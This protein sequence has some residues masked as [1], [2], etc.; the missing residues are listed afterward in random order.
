MIRWRAAKA[1]NGCRLATARSLAGLYPLTGRNAIGRQSFDSWRRGGHVYQCPVREVAGGNDPALRIFIYEH[2]TGGG[3]LSAPARPDEMASLP[4]EGQ[5]MVAALADDLAAIDGVEVAGLRDRRLAPIAHRHLADFVRSLAADVGCRRNS[6][7]FSYTVCPAFAI[8]GAQSEVKHFPP[9]CIEVATPDERDAA[10]DQLAGAA[11]WTVVIAP[12]IGGALVERCRRVVEV[13]GRLLG[14]SLETLLVASDKHATAQ[15]LAAAGVPVPYGVPHLL[16]KPW[17]KDFRYPA[18][19]K[20]L[21]GA[22][23]AGLRFV[24]HCDVALLSQAARPGR[25]EELCPKSEP[26]SP[27]APRKDVLSR[28]ER[29]QSAAAASCVTNRSIAASVA[30]LCGPAGCFELPPCRQHLAEDFR[31]LGGSLPVE[32]DLANRASRLARR[33]VEALPGPFGFVGVDLVLSCE[34]E[35]GDVVIEINP[36]L[37]TSYVG[38]RAACRGNLAAALLGVAAGQTI[39]LSFRDAAIEWEANGHVQARAAESFSASA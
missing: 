25:L 34:D 38:L 21:D 14:G 5:S 12:E 28:S 37:T 1:A 18:V 23:S 36:R 32:P 13:G 9:R 6:H 15:H 7:E 20:P 35:T 2:L 33:S 10:F 3:L 30:F 4:V 17:P 16:G 11:D 26:M 29:R 8:S 31:Y 24:E 27:F 39:N 19:W 22:G